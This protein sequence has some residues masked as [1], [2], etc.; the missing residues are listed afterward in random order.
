[1]SDDER[2]AADINGARASG[3]FELEGVRWIAPGSKGCA[4]FDALVHVDVRAEIEP[5]PS[6]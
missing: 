5:G 3:F 4:I 1:M 2:A 6:H